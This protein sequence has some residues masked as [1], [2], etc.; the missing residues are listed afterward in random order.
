MNIEDQINELAT[1]LGVDIK[2]LRAAT[3]DDPQFSQQIEDALS[4]R[5]RWDAPQ[6]LTTAN[7]LQACINIGVGEYN[8]DLLAIYLAFKNQFKLAQEEL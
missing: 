4:K 7:K 3:G 5:V 6:D 8:R 1:E 2:A